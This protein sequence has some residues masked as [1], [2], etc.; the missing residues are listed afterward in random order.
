MYFLL[1]LNI[2]LMPR[3]KM[4]SH[5]WKH[6]HVRSFTF[7]LKNKNTYARKWWLQCKWC[8]TCNSLIKLIN[9]SLYTKANNWLVRFGLHCLYNKANRKS[10]ISFCCSLPADSSWSGG[11]W[12][13]LQSKRAS[14]HWDD[15]VHR[16][17]KFLQAEG[18][19][20]STQKDFNLGKCL[21]TQIIIL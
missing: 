21:R 1:Q 11:W 5:S 13:D 8:I 18:G 17:V 14:S 10:D 4:I 3:R 15:G 20:V 12:K 2:I 6:V 9:L 19:K 7:D 16:C